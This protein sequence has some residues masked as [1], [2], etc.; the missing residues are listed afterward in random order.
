MQIQIEER[1]RETTANHQSVV[2]SF[3]CICQCLNKELRHVEKQEGG[4]GK[5][6]IN[7]FNISDTANCYA[8]NV[9]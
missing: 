2:A 5:R 1:E 3:Q 9:K 8:K 6:Q 7:K 4:R